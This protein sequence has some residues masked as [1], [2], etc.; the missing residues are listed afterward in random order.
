MRAV[1][2]WHNKKKAFSSFS[3][4]ILTHVKSRGFQLAEDHNSWAEDWKSSLG[5]LIPSSTSDEFDSFGAFFLSLFFC[6]ALLF[7]ISIFAFW[8]D[9]YFI[10]VFWTFHLDYAG[11]IRR[12]FLS[13]I[14][15]Q[16][17]TMISLWI[18]L[19]FLIN[20]GG[21]K[22]SSFHLACSLATVK[23]ALMAPKTIWPCLTR[24]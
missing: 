17:D 13:W 21:I 5:L 11:Y 20:C 12:P 16:V 8:E 14:N 3:W 23:R 18:Y 2:N 10:F 7:L 22:P 15:I 1:Y 24:F 19:V 4:C 6:N 9:I